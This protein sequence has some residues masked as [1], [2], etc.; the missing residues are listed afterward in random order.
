MRPPRT[1]WKTVSRTAGLVVVA[2]VLLMWSATTVL[3]Q[4]MDPA[5]PLALLGIATLLIGG[6]SGWQLVVRDT[7]GRS[8]GDSSP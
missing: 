1:S 6:P 7:R 3:G 2:T 5:V 8:N 4:Q